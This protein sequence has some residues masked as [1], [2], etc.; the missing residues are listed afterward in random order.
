MLPERVAVAAYPYA[1]CGNENLGNVSQLVMNFTHDIL[2]TLNSFK[3]PNCGQPM[4]RQNV[5]GASVPLWG[6]GASGEFQVLHTRD[7]TVPLILPWGDGS[8]G[9]RTTWYAP[10]EVDVD[11]AMAAVSGSN[12]SVIR[13]FPLN[14]V[15][16]FKGTRSVGSIPLEL[17]FRP[18]FR[19]MVDPS[20]GDH[21][22]ADA[23]NDP[24]GT[25]NGQAS[26][27]VALTFTFLASAALTNANASVQ[28][29]VEWLKPDGGYET[30]PTNNVQVVMTS[31]VVAEGTLYNGTLSADQIVLPIF[32]TG[33][34]RALISIQ[35][36]QPNNVR[37]KMTGVSG[38][39]FVY[40]TSEIVTVM[41][42]NEQM[43]TL[44]DVARHCWPMGSSLL[45]S[46][47]NPELT[48]AGRI[49]AVRL[50]P[51]FGS[52]IEAILAGAEAPALV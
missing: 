23:V 34:H 14:I 5:Y 40:Q 15:S 29:W 2:P 1:R 17:A 37:T 6:T 13:K 8:A 49:R 28:F 50:N 20:G 39:L 21:F 36:G 3:L 11:S 46:N 43:E 30:Y 24:A 51:T 42:Y 19:S 16:A 12:V 52:F 4:V 33:F 45:I 32:Q 27:T 35:V 18:V 9:Y 38:Q 26:I 48:T 10:V 47:E 44:G 31:S 22:W 7:P 25:G 41:L